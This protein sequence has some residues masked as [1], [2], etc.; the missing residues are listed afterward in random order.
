MSG[1]LENSDCFFNVFLRGNVLRKAL[2]SNEAICDW[3]RERLWAFWRTRRIG[4]RVRRSGARIAKSMMPGRV[5]LKNLLFSS[6]DN[7]Y[8]RMNK[9]TNEYD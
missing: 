6:L 1:K 5:C 2:A 7:A 9:S 3:D 4:G 8:A